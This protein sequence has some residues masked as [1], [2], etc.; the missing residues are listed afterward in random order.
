MVLHE[1]HT[2]SSKNTLKRFDKLA[3]KIAKD[4]R[5]PAPGGYLNKN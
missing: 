5:D 4:T 1:V 3:G 2:S